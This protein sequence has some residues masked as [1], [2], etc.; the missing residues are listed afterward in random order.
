ML[1]FP[2][3]PVGPDPTAARWSARLKHARPLIGCRFDPSGRFLFVSAEDETIQRFDLLTGIKVA[4]TGHRSWVRGMAFIGVKAASSRLDSWERE[5]GLAG[6]AG[7]GATALA[8]PK[9]EPFTLV[10]GDYHGQLI[11]WPGD[12]EAPKPIR[13]VE[14]HQGWIRASRQA[15]MARPWRVAATTMRSSCGM[16]RMGNRSA[17]S[18][19]MRRTSTTWPSIRTASGWFPCDLKGVV[20]D[21]NLS[22]GAR[23]RTRCQGALEVRHGIHGRHRRRGSMAFSADGAAACAGITNVSNAFAGVGNP[24]VVLRLEG[25]E[26]P[27][28]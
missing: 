22:T 10:S 28:S 25:R 16:P 26:V 27:S 14:A 1:P 23:A 5:R 15:R 9:P 7:F 17:R 18:R 19:V 11:W 12:A 3:P 8:M 20:K 24:A 13:T 4:F 21:W 6:L 2:R